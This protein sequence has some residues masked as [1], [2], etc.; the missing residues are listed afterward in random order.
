MAVADLRDE[1]S[2]SVCQN[3]YEDPVILRCGHNF[4]STCIG[5][6]LTAQEG[7]GMY[8]CP[9][10]RMQF[11]ERPVLYRNILLRNIAERFRSTHLEE[12]PSRVLCTYCINSSTP[13]VKTCVNCEASLCEGH[14]NVHNKS[15]EHVLIEPTTYLKNLK[16]SKHKKILE[17]YCYEDSVCICVS[18]RLDGIHKGHQVEPIEE[19]FEKKREKWRNVLE[20]LPSQKDEATSR[21]QTLL[22]HMEKV[23]RN[24]ASTKKTVMD[25]FRDIKKKLDALE[26]RIVNEVYKQ[27]E[28]ASNSITKLIQ[29]LEVNIDS[30]SEKITMFEK[31][32]S[33]ADPLRVLQ[34]HGVD[35]DNVAKD[36][37]VLEK[38]Q[39]KDDGVKD[40]HERMIYV[41]L[42][43]SLFNIVNE[44]RADT[45]Q[46]D[47]DLILDEDTAG[48]SVN[49][50]NDLK[51]VT[52]TEIQNS[53]PRTPKRFSISQVLSKT[54]FSSGQHYWEIE[55]SET[56]SW[57]VGVAYA[58]MDIKDQNLI[59]DNKNSWCL[60]RF[61]DK[62]FVVHD[63]DMISFTQSSSSH[64]VGVY[65]DYE[66][67]RLSFYEL[68]DPVRH[69]HTFHT[70]FTEPLHAAFAVHNS[71]VKIM[72]IVH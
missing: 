19:A 58:S 16:C 65:L 54:S 59:G 2:C 42:F 48:N 46:T 60:R 18:C 52:Y 7:S 36:C 62:Y 37:K 53:L 61:N 35:R 33:M 67:G 3:V 26:E 44:V 12:E 39:R 57:R 21:I 63:E 30:I 49:L 17:Y 9:Q 23:I 8:S 40:F 20:E 47:L 66:D 15:S 34:D 72:S 10:C 28:E 70:T 6:V 29:N 38:T 27:E 25:M 5:K 56:G 24:A 43:K 32:Y 11:E 14:V 55:T 31:M 69:I 13:A 51:I 4:C 64:N 45:L 68:C 1:L 41:Q 50:S 22:S 71:Y